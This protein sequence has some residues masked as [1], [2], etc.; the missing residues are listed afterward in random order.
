MVEQ[1]TPP[2]KSD[3]A[4]DPPADSVTTTLHNS[5]PFIPPPPNQNLT[6]LRP[7]DK[8]DRFTILEIL[9]AGGFGTVY[10]AQQTSPV[11]RTVALKVINIGLNTKEVLARFE[12]E[13]Q[14]L[15]LM[16]HPNIA[17]VIDGGVTGTGRPFFVMDYVPGKP[18]TAFADENHLT[19]NERL[20]LF[21]QVCRAIAHAHT[22]AIIHRD[23][24]ASNV[25][26]YI[27]D[28][29]PAIKVIDFGIAKALTGDHLSSITINTSQGQII[30]TYDY[31]SPE[32]AAGL[33]DIDTRSDVYSLGV[34]LYELLTGSKPLVFK[35]FK[36]HS[37]YDFRRIIREI[38]PPRPSTRIST[39]GKA[40]TT[41]AKAR[42]ATP[43]SLVKELRTELEW[44]PLKALRKDRAERYDSVAALEADIQRYLDG[45]PLVAGPDS[46][47]YKTK[48]FLR[49]HRFPA[50][51]ALAFTLLLL[52]AAAAYIHAI[53]SGE[54]HE[55]TARLV[56][57]EQ[58]RIADHERT[59]A[60][61]SRRQAQVE[62][63]D[64]RRAA[65]RSEA[66]YLTQQGLLPAALQRATE[67]YHLGGQLEDGFTFQEISNAATKNWQLR[68]RIPCPDPVTAACYS[69][70]LSQNGPEY[71]CLAH[72]RDIE[73]LGN[74]N[75][76]GSAYAG[77]ATRFSQSV[78]PEFHATAHADESPVSMNIN[79][80]TASLLV[81]SADTVCRFELPTLKLLVSRSFDSRIVLSSPS[82]SELALVHGDGTVRSIRLSDL[83]DEASFPWTR[84]SAT[85]TLDLPRLLCASPDG[86]LVL[87]HSGPWWAKTVVWDR[88][89][90]PPSFSTAGIRLS[91]YQFVNNQQL[92]SWFIADPSGGMPVELNLY[93]RALDPPYPIN[94]LDDRRVRFDDIKSGPY[95]LH[96]WEQGGHI[97]AGIVGSGGCVLATFGASDVDS[98]ERFANLL[99]FESPPPKYVCSA[100]DHSRLFLQHPGELLLFERPPD[101][102]NYDDSCAAVCNHG[103]LRMRSLT[104]AASLD[105]EPFDV[106]TPSRYYSLQW[107][108][109]EQA[110]M[111]WIS[112]ALA[113]NQDGDTV[114]A[115]AQESDNYNAVGAHYGRIRAL[116]YKPGDLQ[117][118][119]KP[120]P[121]DRQFDLPLRPLQNFVLR[122]TAVDPRGDILFFWTSANGA[123]RFSLRDGTL[124]GTLPLD[125]CVA[126]ST[127]GRFVAG[128]SKDGTLRAYDL[129]SAQP[130]FQ[131]DGYSAAAGICFSADSQR[132]FVSRLSQIESFQ[133][134]PAGQLPTISS[135]HIPLAFPPDGSRFIAFDRD[136][137][138]DGGNIVLDDA[139][140]G[141]TLTVLVRSSYSAALAAFSPSG[142]EIAVV[143]NRWSA[144]VMRS[145]SPE[146]FPSS[147]TG[148]GTEISVFK[149]LPLSEAPPAS[150]PAHNGP[151]N[152]TDITALTGMMGR[153]V[154]VS[155]IVDSVSWTTAHNALN[156]EFEGPDETRLMCWLPPAALLRF[157]TAFGKDFDVAIAHHAIIVS[158]TV[159]T[160]G[161][162]KE[163]W[164]RR[165]PITLDD[166]AQLTL[167]PSTTQP[168]K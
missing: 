56:A 168:A 137:Q 81:I 125:D 84:T 152:A 98:S 80:P 162:R 117:T 155:G 146:D 107:L 115:I 48:K 71:L 73:L 110:N 53:K 133:L 14:A 138:G 64:A 120:W 128:I 100:L 129:A 140:D 61:D 21:C 89:T 23:L 148:S 49:R 156:V 86:R 142:R 141:N 104:E 47:T 26:A 51:A 92:V 118:S 15:A 32:Q 101:T 40:A 122:R 91:Q 45:K 33:A 70:Q 43:D 163:G 19:L 113:T 105:F 67:A 160:Y 97:H 166:P 149:Q 96:A 164:R 27:N 119:S 29:K 12:A 158:G 88:T 87:L 132:L 136:P 112:R 83:S 65:A 28:N 8:L 145:L 82:D 74:L 135:S 139:S 18:V 68:A 60:E 76:R 10:K 62:S 58:R 154:V 93:A 46:F 143:Q 161:G 55:R 36:N 66:R 111:T 38:D 16:D 50:A 77:D 159:G 54:E 90:S 78:I 9:G 124:L 6:D 167:S 131:R 13:R 150:L 153:H 157:T 123:S 144:N 121:I 114:V 94:P 22:K 69:P 5:S 4:S 79:L 17:R 35:D 165:L 109:D 102:R 42:R 75:L 41:T 108:N 3:P 57:D 99:P 59:I 95:E 34:L 11:R 2:F 127:D 44:I 31:M 134:N 126:C 1:N 151:L 63:I 147:V 85:A 103:L 30:G 7:G 24:K 39:L 106:R 72:G 25:L 130:V 52:A 20:E 37:E 116:V